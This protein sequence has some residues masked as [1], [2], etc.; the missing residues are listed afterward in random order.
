MNIA[1]I[2]PHT[3]LFG[4]VKR[5]VEIGRAVLARGHRF[6]I[7]TPE[8]RYPDW[9]TYPGTIRPLSHFFEEP[10][11]AVIFSEARFLDYVQKSH[12]RL[13]C[14][15]VI[16][17]TKALRRIHCY[18]D[19]IFF[20]NSSRAMRWVQRCIGVTP[21]PVFG[22]INTDHYF[23]REAEPPFPPFTVITY[24]RQAMKRKGTHL[25]KAACERLYKKG[26]DIK[27]L[28]FDTAS[29]PELAADITNFRAA[30]PFEFV[31]NH[32]PERNREL[33]CRAHCFA[34]AER[35]G[36]WANTASE[37]MACG[38]PVIA[39]AIG[40][41]DFL[42]PGVTG[43]RVR[44]SAR[45]I[46]KA[47]ARLYRDAELR[48]R[49]SAAGARRVRHY[50]WRFSADNLL[51]LLAH[52]DPHRVSGSAWPFTA[53]EVANCRVPRKKRKAPPA[54]RLENALYII[55]YHSICDSRSMAPWE[56][57]L[58]DS[59]TPLAHFTAHLQ[60]MRDNA[61]PVKL[62]ECEALFERGNLDKPYFA[63][64]FD[65][66][67]RTVFRTA[68]PV[69][70][71][72]GVT[73]ALC[74]CS[75]FAQGG[76]FCNVILGV[77]IASQ[78]F[79][80]IATQL[81]QRFG[82]KASKPKRL[83]RAIKQ[84]A[85]YPVIAQWIQTRGAGRVPDRPHLSMEELRMLAVKGWNIVN[86]TRD[87]CLLSSLL[88]EEQEERIESCRETF[89]HYGIRML[90]WLAVPFGLPQHV[91]QATLHWLSS[92]PD[93]RCMFANGGV[94]RQFNRMEILRI[95]IGGQDLKGFRDTL[96][97]QAVRTP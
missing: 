56:R 88:I 52:P 84:H 65:D 50:Q 86:H 24:G 30:C 21:F 57:Y 19:I 51:A 73:P 38:V 43:L 12:A 31:A 15:Y 69:L 16:S 27:L 75:D 81:R 17:Q 82:L 55:N 93:Y 13:K 49:L 45:S 2:L 23:P 66:G 14:F 87:H 54:F 8:G 62:A 47:I 33:Y 42:V 96:H 92:R 32:P 59:V 97:E 29:T 40:S 71:R 6:V 76:I 5:Y 3:L 83:L 36:M 39:S 41:G 64:T 9:C 72:L 22:G 37:A 11:D 25:V 94:N 7:F 28:L 60:W 79:T 34:S 89:E 35:K 1:G 78:G 77:L 85:D 91:N 48:R 68:A 74:V 61:E 67:Y 4:G 18:R 70:D 26:Y 63:V 80:T 53:R 20:A 95:G 46:A 10:F 58:T 44:L 90:H